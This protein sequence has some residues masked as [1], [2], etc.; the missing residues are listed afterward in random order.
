[1]VAKCAVN[2]YLIAIKRHWLYC[3]AD[4]IIVSETLTFPIRQ[5]T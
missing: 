5:E 2:S 1:L 4:G 3:T